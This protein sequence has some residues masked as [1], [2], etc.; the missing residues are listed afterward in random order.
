VFANYKIGKKL[1][2]SFGIV[3]AVLVALSVSSLFSVSGLVD[4]NRWNT[5][6][7]VVMGEADKMLESLINMETGQR[8][9]MLAGEDAF[10]EP[11]RSGETEFQ[12]ALGKI[13][14]LTSDNPKQQ[15]RLAA[16]GTAQR[17]WVSQVLEP[18]IALRRSVSE[19]QAPM[20][21]VVA[22]VAAANGKKHMDEMRRQLAEIHGEEASL[23][24]QRSEDVDSLQT[25][26]FVVIVLGTLLSVALAVALAMWITRNIT[27]PLGTA[28]DALTRLERGDMDIRIDTESQDEF[29]QML[30]ATQRT[31]EQVRKLVGAIST[32]STQHDAGE[33]DARIAAADFPGEFG[34]VARGVND[35]AAGHVAVQRKVID[36]VAEFGMGN[37]NASLERFAGQRVFINES[38]ERVRSRFKAVISDTEQMIGFARA[39]KLEERA[40]AAAHAGDFRSVIEGINAMLDAIVSPVQETARVLRAMESGDLTQTAEAACHGQLKEMCDSLNACIVKLSE[41]VAEVNGG[42]ISLASASEQVSAT[43]QSLSQAASQQAAGVEETSASIEEMTGSISLNTDNAK[44]TDGMASRSAEEAIEGGEAV[45]ATV[46]AMRE[47]AQKIGVID[48]IASQTNLLALNA[49]IEAARA[50][51][52]GRG[53]AVVAAEVRK[54][55]ERSRV[56]AQEIGKVAGSSVS[57]AERAGQLLSQMVPNIKKTSELVQEIASASGEQASGVGQINAA[58]SQLSEATQQNA[59]GSEEL[60]ATAEEMSSQAEQLQSTMAFF[61]LRQAQGQPGASRK[62]AGRADSTAPRRRLAAVES[63]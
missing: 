18:E 34:A 42:A 23:L 35:M 11:Y 44:V 14:E 50:G 29:G 12:A 2:Y 41:V 56:A 9:F 33:I 39:G 4:A 24:K 47:I 13:K 1:Y 45:K 37:F 53:F 6:T 36:C 51:E 20:D 62:A 7:Y 46:A 59:S 57:L 58:M 49:A 8:G 55:A 17:G 38:I 60:A 30:R 28:V 25:R 26:T 21:A 61:S 16:L 54:L 19:G 43:A 15:E 40:D 63:R 32:M 27:G 22:E 31:S 52:N 5:H 3:V 48:D 10:L